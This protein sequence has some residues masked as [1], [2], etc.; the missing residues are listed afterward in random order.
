[1]LNQDPS[2]D[3]SHVER[4]ISRAEKI[5]DAESKQQSN[6]GPKYDLQVIRLAA[7]L[8]DVADH[9]YLSPGTDGTV[10]AADALRH[11]GATP[12][13]C[14]KVQDIVNA[15]S[16]SREKSDP[17][18]VDGVLRRHPEL[19]VVQDADR[20][21]ALGAVGIARCCAYRGAKGATGAK[22]GMKL[23]SVVTHIDEKLST[24]E[25]IM[26]T[27]T[28]KHR[29]RELTDRMNTIRAWMEEELNP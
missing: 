28:G 5:Y 7:L 25:G 10:V 3:F 6:S 4:V 11:F 12:E 23:N 27:E 1:M 22:A 13:L 21:D 29:A 15:V 9:K 17:A 8:H 14:D 24:L 26:K 16:F 2:H 18:F 19:A 20:L